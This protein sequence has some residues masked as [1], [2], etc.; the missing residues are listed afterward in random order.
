MKLLILEK[1][2]YSFRLLDIE[3]RKTYRALSRNFNIIFTVG[4][5]LE[6]DEVSVSGDL[7]EAFNLITETVGD[8]TKPRVELCI[9]DYKV[10]DIF[11]GVPILTLGKSYAKAGKKV[12]YAYFK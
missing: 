11:E 10:G 8:S 4:S 5:L 9:D 3:S 6:V 12:A 7:I 1:K 2:G